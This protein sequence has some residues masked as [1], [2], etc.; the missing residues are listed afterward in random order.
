MTAQELHT[1]RGS[2]TESDIR[3]MRDNIYGPGTDK[4]WD[5]CKESWK[6][7]GSVDWLMNENAKEVEKRKV[8]K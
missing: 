8:R 4:N 7:P 3:K 5:D 2:M 1:L 6:Q